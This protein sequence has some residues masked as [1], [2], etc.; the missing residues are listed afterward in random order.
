M[1]TVKHLCFTSHKEVMMRDPQDVGTMINFLALNSWKHHVTILADCEMSTHVHLIVVGADD[2]VS[3][4]I[5]DVRR[6]YTMYMNRK[7]SRP[8]HERFG[9]KGYFKLDIFGNNHIQSALSYVLR[10]PLHHG[11]T[12]TPFAYPYSSVNDIFPVEMGKLDRPH[13]SNGKTIE[14]AKR[15]DGSWRKIERAKTSIEGGKFIESRQVMASFLPRYSQ[16]PD[17]WKMTSDG[18]F[19]RLSFEDLKQTELQFVTPGGF[20]YCMFRK[21]DE[22]WLQE[23]ELDMNGLAPIDLACMEPFSDE[24]EVRL[25]KSNEKAGTFRKT[26][27]NDF[28]VC[29]IVD[30]DIVK[31]FRYHS[32][33]EL[34][35]SQKQAVRRILISELRIPAAQAARCVPMTTHEPPHD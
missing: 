4:F 16:W 1:K 2:D 5:K 28:D 35:E 13:L 26:F 20:Q 7:Y 22:N 25:F 11:V 3:D 27:L 8:V 31:S 6:Q 30:N 14:L 23:Q 34:T 29:R 21:S 33:Y 10:N 9:E 19:S 15:R 17:D 24:H 12:G 32:V 18:V